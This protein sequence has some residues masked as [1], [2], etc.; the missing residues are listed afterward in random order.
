MQDIQEVSRQRV[1]SAYIQLVQALTSSDLVELPPGASYRH[2]SSAVL[3][4]GSL[5]TSGDHCSIISKAGEG[6]APA[7]L[8]Q[9]FDIVASLVNAVPSARGWSAGRP[10]QLVSACEKAALR[11]FHAAPASPMWPRQGAVKLCWQGQSSV[12]SPTPQLYLTPS[13]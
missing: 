10:L 9:V 4:R 7:C 5:R 11:Q 8:K 6:A 2:A 1:W 13:D 3:L 12:L